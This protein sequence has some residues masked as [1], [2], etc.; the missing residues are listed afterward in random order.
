MIIRVGCHSLE[1]IVIIT[2]F[3]DIAIGTVVVGYLIIH[4]TLQTTTIILSLSASIS[5]ILVIL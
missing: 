1:K 4:G 5:L 3:M 2:N